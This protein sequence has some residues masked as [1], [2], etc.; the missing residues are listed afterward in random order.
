MVDLIHSLKYNASLVHSCYSQIQKKTQPFTL[1]RTHL[2]SMTFPT[3]RGLTTFTHL[4]HLLIQDLAATGHP[5]YQTQEEQN[6]EL[7]PV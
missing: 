5:I 7:H 3:H 6:D 1:Y 4:I 2:P